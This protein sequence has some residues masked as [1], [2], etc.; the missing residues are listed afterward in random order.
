MNVDLDK[1]SELFYDN[2]NENLLVQHININTRHKLG[3]SP[4]RLYLIF[5]NEEDMVDDI[6]CMAPFGKH[7]HIGLSFKLV[8]SA[9][10][11]INEHE[12]NRLNYHKA[13]YNKINLLYKMTQWAILFKHK[14]LQNMWRI[15]TTNYDNIVQQY[16][17]EYIR[18]TTV[19]KIWR[20]AR[21]KRQCASKQKK[22]NKYLTKNRYIDY[23]EYTQQNNKT[24]SVIRSAKADLRRN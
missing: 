22:W 1:E 2:I 20:R 10:M 19:K 7:D 24:I 14:L 9:I 12:E 15:F 11:E 6:K 4:S 5:T 16:T 17:P 13:N 18:R 21:V 3:N 23:V 8:T